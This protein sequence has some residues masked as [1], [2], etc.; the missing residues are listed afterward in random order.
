MGDNINI[1]SGNV[2]SLNCSNK[3]GMSNGCSVIC[4]VI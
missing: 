3:R 2:W 4:V 1:I